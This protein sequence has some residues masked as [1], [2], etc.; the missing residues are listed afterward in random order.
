MRREE[1]GGHGRIVQ[2]ALGACKLPVGWQPAPPRSFR[3]KLPDAASGH[4]WK[5]LHKSLIMIRESRGSFRNRR[6]KAI[7]PDFLARYGSEACLLPLLPVTVCTCLPI[8][9]CNR[10]LHRND[11]RRNP[12][13]KNAMPC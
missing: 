10:Y 9:S 6:F 2:D 4:L 13:R 7:V 1:F 12:S 8:H 5:S 11:L 3:Q